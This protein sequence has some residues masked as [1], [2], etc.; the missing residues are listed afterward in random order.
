M[1][2]LK[3]KSGSHF[4]FKEA[5][6]EDISPKGGFGDWLSIGRKTPPDLLATLY[7]G[8]CAAMMQEMATA[9]GK[10]EVASRF[11]AEFILIKR[12]L[13]N[14]YTDSSGKFLVDAAAYGDGAGYIDGKVGFDGH[15]QT[16]YANAIYMNML[17]PD[18]RVKAGKWLHE[19]LLQ[20]EGSLTTGFL[21]F[22]PLLPA[23]SATGNAAMAYNLLLDTSYPSLGYEIVNGATSIWER[24]DSFTKEEGFKHNA[25]MNS[26][27]HYAFGAVNEW[28]F[29]NMAGIQIKSAGYKTF[30]I[31]P[32]IAREKINYVKATYHSISGIITSSWKKSGDN[33]QL[34]ITVP[35]N[36]SAE[37]YVPVRDD[38]VMPKSKQQVGSGAYE[39]GYRIYKVG[40]GTYHFESEL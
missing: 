6:F 20:N 25:A 38:K 14:Y 29:S 8:Y 2:F 17:D 39:Q 23:L 40:S 7:Y 5:T 13:K 22:K 26:F 32:E 10:K 34:E 3:T 4:L 15:T 30:S 9:I 27:S 36:T 31:K 19:L 28:M 18:L 1:D 11:A 16:A 24:W 37:I 35:V 33:I 21:G 12:E